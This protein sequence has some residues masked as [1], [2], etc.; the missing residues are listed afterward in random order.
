MAKAAKKLNGKISKHGKCLSHLKCVEIA[1]KRTEDFT[2]QAIDNGAALWRK[3]NERRLK[4]TES[5]MRTAYTICK[6]DLSFK[7]QPALTELQR[8]NGLNLCNML[9]SDKA[10]RN[11]LMF[12]GEKMSAL[13]AEYVVESLDK[14]SILLDESTTSSNKTCLIVYICIPFQN[15]AC[16]FLTN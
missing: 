9:Q 12:I 2:E 5:C 13:L 3:A 4:V 1:K 7:I 15:Q 6:N 16:N 14:F 11:I 10:C 8:L